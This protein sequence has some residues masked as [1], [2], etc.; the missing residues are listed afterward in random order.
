MEPRNCSR[1]KKL[2]K[3]SRG[4]KRNSWAGP[5]RNSEIP[6]VASHDSQGKRKYRE[7]VSVRRDI[8]IG[9]ALLLGDM[10]DKTSRRTMS[11]Q[12]YIKG[13]SSRPRVIEDDG[14]PSTDILV[15]STSVKIPMLFLPHV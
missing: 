14:R 15:D 11:S 9:K 4:S 2:S 13:S 8:S 3:G 1:R 7:E 6:V 5:S 10:D 12:M